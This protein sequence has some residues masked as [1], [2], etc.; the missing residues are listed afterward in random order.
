MGTPQL[1]GG[2]LRGAVAAGR[3]HCAFT[4]Q[5]HMSPS[6]VLGRIFGALA[7]LWVRMAP[8]LL[9]AFYVKE[10][11]KDP[12][13]RPPPH[14]ALPLV[15]RSFFCTRD[16]RM[17]LAFSGEKAEATAQHRAC[18]VIKIHLRL[19]REA[20]LLR[21]ALL[22]HRIRQIHPQMVAGIATNHAAAL[23]HTQASQRVDRLNCSFTSL[24]H[25][26]HLGAEL[27]YLHLLHLNNALVIIKL[28]N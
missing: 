4:L 15:K 14:R 2:S 12:A 20:W 9:G 10:G 8:L 5:R 18:L 11:C 24:L 6:W 27:T 23:A 25:V 7:S 28:L 16:L 13:Q 26:R 1:A 19:L 22:L 17:A 3:S 21:E